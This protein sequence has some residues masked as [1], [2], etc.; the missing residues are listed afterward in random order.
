M[1]IHIPF[2]ITIVW[3]HIKDFMP[4]IRELLNNINVYNKIDSWI[5]KKMG[6]KL[7]LLY[8]VLILATVATFLPPIIVWI[9]ELRT[10]KNYPDFT[11]LG[12]TEW[13]TM[14]SLLVTTYF[15]VDHMNNRLS[16]R[17]NADNDDDE[18]ET[19]KDSLKHDKI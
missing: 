11:I 12:S 4:K 3:I 8:V 16:A 10:G 6:R 7:T 17:N 5:E 19:L 13:V 14:I 15:G 18:K 2:I 9:L 1:H